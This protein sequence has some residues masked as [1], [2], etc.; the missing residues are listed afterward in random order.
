MNS[1][2]IILQKRNETHRERKA[3]N[4]FTKNFLKG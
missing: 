2:G 1:L 4:L 3:L